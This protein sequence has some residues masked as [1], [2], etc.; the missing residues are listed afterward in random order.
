MIKYQGLKYP[1]RLALQQRV[2]GVVVVDDVPQLVGHVD[3]L[4]AVLLQ[5][6]RIRAHEQGA[7]L[8]YQLLTLRGA[9]VAPS[10]SHGQHGHAR[11]IEVRQHLRIDQLEQLARVGDELLVLANFCD[12]FVGGLPD[13][14]IRQAVAI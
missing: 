3:R 4:A 12:D 1:V 2:L 7:K 14:R 11:K 9:R 5:G 10:P 8:L 13:Q 6:G